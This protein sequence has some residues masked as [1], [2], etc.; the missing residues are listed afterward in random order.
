MDKNDEQP[1]D[2]RK[3]SAGAQN[4][5]APEKKEARWE[6][7][8]QAWPVT[9][10][11][12]EFV[13][14]LGFKHAG[15][16][17]VVNNGN[18]RPGP[19]FSYGGRAMGEVV[20]MAEDSE[21]PEYFTRHQVEKWRETEQFPKRRLLGRFTEVE[22]QHAGVLGQLFAT[23]FAL[24]MREKLK[25]T[26]GSRGEVRVGDCLHFKEVDGRDM[27]ETDAY[28]Y[29][30]A[31]SFHVRFTEFTNS[32]E[33]TIEVLS[34]PVHTLPAMTWAGF[35]QVAIVCEKLARLALGEQQQ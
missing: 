1:H 20:L 9:S 17:V 24:R 28:F 6:I 30:L 3:A 31:G 13:T 15:V 11:N 18:E 29:A 4:T 14:N 27:W 12:V 23:Y 35:K 19:Q 2:A 34:A 26:D 5:A 7:P 8:Y 33:V 25:D 32:E 21:Q 22:R 16:A 10:M